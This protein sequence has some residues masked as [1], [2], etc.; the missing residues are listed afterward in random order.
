MATTISGIN[1]ALVDQRIVE[2]LRHVLPLIKKFS[3][4]IDEQDRI[5]SDTV[6]VPAATDP[7]V[8]DKTA[9]TFVTA[10]GTLAGTVVTFNK[11][12]GAGWDAVEGTMRASLLP[13]YWADKAAGAVYGVAKDVIDT[14]LALITAANYSNVEGT[15][16]ITVP[17]ADFGQQD[18]ARLWA[19]AT[20][21]IKRQKKLLMLG[22]DYAAAVF[23]DSNLALINATAGK[24]DLTTA[25]LPN[26][27]D[28][29]QAIYPDFPTTGNLGGAVIGAASMA[30][31][32]CNP[33]GFLKSGDGN[34][35]E[36]RVITD[37]DSGLSAMYT[38]KADAGGTLSGE[39]AM[40]FGVGK[41]QDS[42]VRLVSA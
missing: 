13:Q 27:L 5:A 42:V 30:V 25:N 16:K 12:R 40:Q 26:F 10:T 11:F 15:D 4:I 18:M 8:G 33:S 17:A 3:Y 7:T 22:T 14:L 36:R 41:I 34:V 2:A 6:Y 39:V 37:P 1:E 23:G 9:G 31:A 28:I 21:K 29:E 20:K 19:V 38:V 35:L 24:A 32:L